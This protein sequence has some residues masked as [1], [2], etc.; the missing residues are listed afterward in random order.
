MIEDQLKAL[1]SD[2]TTGKISYGQAM[3]R[4]RELRHTVMKDSTLPRDKKAYLSLRLGEEAE[5]PL[6]SRAVN[7]TG[8]V[9]R[10]DY[11]ILCSDHDWTYD[12]SDDPQVQRRG[13]LQRHWL[14]NI[15]NQNSGYHAIYQQ[16]H[17]Y[18]FNTDGYGNYTLP[19]PVYQ[20]E[21]ITL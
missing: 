9:T 16:W 14:I 20:P 4:L 19:K 21:E 12:Y 1:L 13:D 5:F 17:D 6:R 3:S 7:V 11:F 15:A 8:F 18:I 10:Q 2:V